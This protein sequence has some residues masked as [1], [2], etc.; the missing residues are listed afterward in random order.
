MAF[1]SSHRTYNP[2]L[3]GQCSACR[4][5]SHQHKVAKCDNCILRVESGE[6][7]LVPNL[8]WKCQAGCWPC[9]WQSFQWQR[10]T[11]SHQAPWWSSWQ[12]SQ[13]CAARQMAHNLRPVLVSA[14]QEWCSLMRKRNT[15]LSIYF[16]NYLQL[17]PCIR[18][19]GHSSRPR[20]G[21]QSR[22]TP[23]W[24]TAWWSPGPSHKSEKL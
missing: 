17:R 16:N 21:W 14:S 10:S 2:W 11:S 24:W 3:C 7:G 1:L 9:H 8:H 12:C 4:G 13:S 22:A 6:V 18:G 23:W 5:C 19:G 20:Q 15:P